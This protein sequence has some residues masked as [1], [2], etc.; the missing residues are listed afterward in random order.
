MEAAFSSETLVTM[1]HRRGWSSD[2]S[3]DIFGRY[4]VRISLWTSAVLLVISW[5]SSVLPDK[6]QCNTPIIPWPFL[7]KSFAIQLSYHSTVYRLDA[8]SM[9]EESI[10]HTLRH[11]PE[12]QN[13][14][15]FRRC[16]DLRC[17]TAY[18]P[19]HSWLLSFFPPMILFTYSSRLVTY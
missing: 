7:S 4:S 2:N 1:C 14:L 19:I 3:V 9:V 13:I 16:G 11:N 18:S 10:K 12:D 8:G 5:F 6:C 17:G 15:H